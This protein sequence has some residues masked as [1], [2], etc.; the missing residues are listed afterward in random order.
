MK[1]IFLISAALVAFAGA[2]L[3]TAAPPVFELSLA[4][5]VQ[6]FEASEAIPWLAVTVAAIV[7]TV[8]S[9][10]GIG[11]SEPEQKRSFSPI[12]FALILMKWLTDLF[13]PVPDHA[14]SG[15]DGRPI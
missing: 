15:G 1:R 2:A 7:A 12:A 14:L 11:Q 4:P 6:I 9:F 3:A 5:A 8:A 13:K 10:A